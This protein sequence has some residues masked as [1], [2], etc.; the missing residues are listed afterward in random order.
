MIFIII[1]IVF[2]LI[3]FIAYFGDYNARELQKDEC[4]WEEILGKKYY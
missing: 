4:K 3:L 1:A 2:S